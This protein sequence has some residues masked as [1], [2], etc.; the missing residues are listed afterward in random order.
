MT[1]RENPVEKTLE[2]HVGDYKVYSCRQDQY[3]K[4]VLWVQTELH[5]ALQG[6]GW[7]QFNLSPE[8]E[9][10]F[11]KKSVASRVRKLKKAIV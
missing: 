6:S 3:G 10:K 11:V 5:G 1:A 4:K 2:A 9:A 8:D 7:F